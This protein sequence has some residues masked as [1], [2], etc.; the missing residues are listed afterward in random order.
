MPN[1]HHRWVKN[2][3]KARA[4]VTTTRTRPRLGTRA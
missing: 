3:M 2:E 1:T 4:Y